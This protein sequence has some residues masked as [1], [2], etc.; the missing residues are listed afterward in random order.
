MI[1]GQAAKHERSIR[2][3]LLEHSHPLSTMKGLDELV[4]KMAHSK[5]VMLGEASHGT[6]EYYTWRTYI[7]KKLIAEHGFSF[8]GVEGDWPDCFEVNQFVKHRLPEPTTAEAVLR[9]FDRWPTWMWANWEIVALAQWMYDY[10][11]ERTGQQQAGFYGLDVYSLWD[12]LSAVQQY[13]REHAPGE[14]AQAEQAFR[15]FAPYRD[16]ETSYAYAAQAVPN[17]CADEVTGLLKQLRAQRMLSG[18]DAEQGFSA[19]QNALVTVNAET[20]YRTMINGGAASWNIRDSH[21]AETLDRLLRFH[22]PAAKAIV[23]EHNTHIGDA[24]ATTM[25]DEGMYN[26]GE[27]ARKRYGEEQVYLVGFGSYSGTV[28]AAKAW[29]AEQE[30]MTVPEAGKGSW[31][32]HLHQAGGNRLL[33]SSQLKGS[34]LDELALGH[35]AIGVVYRP[36]YEQYGNYVPSRIL[37]RYDA[38]LYIE[39]TKA[40][41]PLHGEMQTT[42]VP[43][44]FPF[45]V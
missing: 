22:G 32:Y 5:V 44:T 38:F 28:L 25:T 37:H 43:D 41:H 39:R 27:L 31:E 26:I 35:R 36:Q 14:L 2:E 12:S 11:K 10:N 9:R 24:R 17:R 18:S 16:D 34:I 23:W 13:L 19:E 8:V 4:A 33:Y 15:C 42:K 20:Y 7:T 40:L 29:G 1:Q 6:H 30:I 3:T 21:M 45:G